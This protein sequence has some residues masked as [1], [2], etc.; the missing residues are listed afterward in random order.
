MQIQIIIIYYDS[1]NC[2]GLYIMFNKKELLKTPNSELYSS[3]SKIN[4]MQPSFELVDYEI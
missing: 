1:I 3:Q 4:I 2:Y